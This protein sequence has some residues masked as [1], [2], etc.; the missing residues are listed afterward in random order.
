VRRNDLRNRPVSG[1]DR[2]IKRIAVAGSV[3][4]AVFLV[5]LLTGTFVRTKTVTRTATVYA[6]TST[7]VPAGCTAAIRLTRQLEL[8][9]NRQA[10]PGLTR[11]FESA[12]AGCAIP[13]GCRQALTYFS[14][15]ASELDVAKLRVLDRGFTAA[16]A[17]CQ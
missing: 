8:T 5:G 17:T 11:R 9:A 3:A 13:D 4:L 12:A 14:R 6:T 7:G 15:I 16:A 2:G 1:Y 10:I